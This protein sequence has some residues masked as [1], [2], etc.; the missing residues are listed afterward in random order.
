MGYGKRYDV[1]N[2][3]NDM[4]CYWLYK[5][6]MTGLYFLQ[7]WNNIWFFYSECFISWCCSTIQA[8]CYVQLVC[9]DGQRAEIMRVGTCQASFHLASFYTL[10]A[11]VIPDGYEQS[12]L[13]TSPWQLTKL[14][15]C[16]C[17]KKNSAQKVLSFLSGF[18]NCFCYW[19]KIIIRP[20]ILFSN[21]FQLF[22][23]T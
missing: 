8:R 10:Y 14:W 18:H 21:Q 17:R 19:G 5:E 7:H 1:C 22:S 15:N 23:L 11:K 6:S 9:S 4:S 3:K 2:Q 13:L 12:W 20:T 16:V